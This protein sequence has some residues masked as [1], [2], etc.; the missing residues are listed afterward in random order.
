MWIKKEKMIQFFKYRQNS[1]FQKKNII[2]LVTNSHTP[3]SMM[4]LSF[5]DCRVSCCHQCAA[6][7]PPLTA[8]KQPP[9]V[10]GLLQF[11]VT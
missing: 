7:L 9:T 6:E 11:I 10:V 5:L 8:Y 3:P 4:A 1:C 2:I